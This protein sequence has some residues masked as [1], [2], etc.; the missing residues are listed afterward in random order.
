MFVY[1]THTGSVFYVHYALKQECSGIEVP[2]LIIFLM[3]SE[4]FL[5]LHLFLFAMRPFKD[6]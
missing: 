5:L 2:G 4:V 1:S 6:T 3:G